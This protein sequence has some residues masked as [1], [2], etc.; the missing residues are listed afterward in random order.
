M[1]YRRCGSSGL[2]VSFLSI[3]LWQNHG[4][5]SDERDTRDVI[6]C[7]FDNGITSFDLANNYGP[8]PGSA[9]ERF[10]KILK[11]DLCP[12]RDEIIISTK[13]GYPMW[14]GPLGDGGSRK[15]LV[16]SIDQSLKR[17]GA[18]YVDIFYHHRPDMKTPLRETAEALSYIQKS[19]R[20]I[21]IALSN[22]GEELFEMKRIL[23]EDYKTTV[24]IDQ[25]SYSI[26]NKRGD[27]SGTLFPHLE[28]EGVAVFA[29]SPLSQGRLT[30]KYLAGTIPPSSRAAESPFL[31]KDDIT[32]EL[33]KALNRLNSI[34]G[35]RGQKLSHM[36]L[37][38]V[39]ERTGVTSAIIGTRNR[40]QLVDLMGV[41]KNYSSF[42]EEEEKMIDD[43]VRNIS[44]RR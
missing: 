21:Y 41:L 27:E 23:E 29:F 24:I 43:T 34:A 2:N 42:S 25:V 6:R 18:D 28:K 17:L 33:V 8:P 9:E 20:A 31:H 44:F 14:P 39:L 4:A 26:L 7:A 15:H 30:D 36:A 11:R 38:W 40:S 1:E 3:G 13:A 19:G 16:A 37:N 22:Y 5:L 12:Y 10:G 35:E 32:P